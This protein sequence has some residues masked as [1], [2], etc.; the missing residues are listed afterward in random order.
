MGE[1]RRALQG[2]VDGVGTVRGKRAKS[3][4]VNRKCRV[5]T[6]S[7]A[8]N[9]VLPGL[10]R[11]ERDP[12]LVV[13]VFRIKRTLGWPLRSQLLIWMLPSWFAS[14]L[15]YLIAA[16]GKRRGDPAGNSFS[17]RM[18]GLEFDRGVRNRERTVGCE[19]LRTAAFPALNLHNE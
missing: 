4:L 15:R 18:S 12:S 14:W 19:R 10:E 7:S 8:G 17:F 5:C 2:R 6:E 9:A 13:V 11:S 3:L 1:P 16:L